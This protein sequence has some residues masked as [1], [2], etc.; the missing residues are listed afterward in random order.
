[1]KPK[2]FLP[3]FIFT[4]LLAFGIITLIRWLAP[5]NEWF[6]KKFGELDKEKPKK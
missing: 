4:L 6:K 1:M 3:R 5:E 2:N